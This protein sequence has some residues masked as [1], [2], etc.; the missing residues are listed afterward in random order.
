MSSPFGF[1]PC[2][3]YRF[4]LFPWK[5]SSCLFSIIYIIFVITSALKRILFTNV[6]TYYTNLC[7]NTSYIHHE[8]EYMNGWAHNSW[9][10]LLA[11]KSTIFSNVNFVHSKSLLL[12]F[13][14]YTISSNVH[15]KQDRSPLLI[16]H[17]YTISSNVHF[18]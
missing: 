14:I 8:K 4:L 1:V 15:F 13:H 2:R 12:Q 7:Q 9:K 17:K 3:F 18:K 10:I 16:F 11:S 6:K 5:L